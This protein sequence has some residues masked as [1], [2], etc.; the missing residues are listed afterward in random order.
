MPEREDPMK[1]LITFLDRNNSGW[2][3]VAAF[4]LLVVFGVFTL[5]AQSALAEQYSD[6]LGSPDTSLF[7]SGSQLVQM[8]AAYGP[9]GRAEYLHARWNFDLAFPLIY[10]LFFLTSIHWFYKKFNPTLRSW[11]IAIPLL[12]M[13][14]DFAENT[15]A[16]VVMRAFPAEGTWGQFLAPVFTPLKWLAVAACAL[17]VVVG[18]LGWLM[19]IKQEH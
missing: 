16:S 15:A 18:L 6:G 9:V 3:T 11:L 4:A 12:A 5:P 1:Q 7:Y 14:L 19:R 10:T 2:V 8:A 13:L 17:I